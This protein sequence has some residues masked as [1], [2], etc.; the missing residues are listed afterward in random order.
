M[1]KLQNNQIQVLDTNGAAII[2]SGFE[3][4]VDGIR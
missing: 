1:I 4:A 2:Q 3:I